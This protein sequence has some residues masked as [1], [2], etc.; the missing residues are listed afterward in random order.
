MK[1]PVLLGSIL[2]IMM[3][4]SAYAAEA[5]PTALE[6]SDPDYP[7]GSYDV[8]V[9]LQKKVNELADLQLRPSQLVTIKD[10]MLDQQRASAS[11]YTSMPTP[12]TRSMNVKFTPGLTPP[13]IRLSANMLSTIVFTDASGNPWNIAGVALNRNLFSDSADV[14][15][16]S[17]SNNSSTAQQPTN[18]AEPTAPEP[19]RNIL[20]IEPLSP[21]AYG[22][23]AIT[24]RGQDSPVIFM[25]STGQSEVD[26]RVDA[27]IAGLSPT[28]LANQA[29]SAS[30][31]SSMDIDDIALRFVDG[32]PPSDA[33]P[34]KTSSPL[35]EAWLF[36][37]QLVVRTK[38][39]I[40]YPSFRSSAT[41]TGG[42]TVYRLDS[43]HQSVTIQ[44]KNGLPLTVFLELQ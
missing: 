1:T 5:A 21:V 25:L 16:S 6:I 38:Q 20:S 37:N 40:L 15:N 24:L 17:S 36:D 12:V 2:S 23:V 27:R 10:M 29:L 42:V 13:V 11:P 22:N 28:G 39:Q 18:P 8:K 3:S 19:N 44:D 34:L 7:G 14:N 4:V 9:E 30:T 32:N 35:I 26:I 41:S 33:A 43:E 31:R